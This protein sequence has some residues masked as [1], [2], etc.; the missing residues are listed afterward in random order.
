M[1]SERTK[2]AELRLVEYALAAERRFS[3]VRACIADIGQQLLRLLLEDLRRELVAR[4]PVVNKGKERL[5]LRDTCPE[6]LLQRDNKG[7][8]LILIKIPVRKIC[9]KRCRC[10][11]QLICP[12]GI[13]FYSL[14]REER[15][16]YY[17]E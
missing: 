9:Q 7:V 17:E 8:Q 13:F 11:D 16:V 10:A 5:D 12:S 1:I 14:N 15:H 2:S 3:Q 6:V 4:R